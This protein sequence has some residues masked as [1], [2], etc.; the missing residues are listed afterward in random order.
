MYSNQAEN[1]ML[2]LVKVRVDVSKMR[3]FAQRLMK[4]ELDRSRIRGETHCLKEDPAVGFSVWEAS[5]R[6][7]FDATFRA[8]REYYSEAEVYEVIPP[9]EA[10][11]ALQRSSQ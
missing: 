6:I 11:I 7:E 3:E 4:G 8:W 2:F 9:M 1:N 5:S 10:M